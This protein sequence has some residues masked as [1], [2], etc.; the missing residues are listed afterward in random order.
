L[1][2][3]IL[4]GAC[5][6]TRHHKRKENPDPATNGSYNNGPQSPHSHFSQQEAPQHQLQANS[7]PVE[8]A[9]QNYQID[10]KEEMRQQV[11]ERDHPIYPRWREITPSPTTMSP[12]SS[13]YSPVTEANLSA[14]EQ[15]M[16][17]MTSYSGDQRSP[18]RN[19]QNQ[20]YYSA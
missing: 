14:L 20:T 6:I 7:I 3:A 17:P 15:Q 12:H 10:P 16:S 1:F 11:N 18:R 2:I 13:S 5:F 4:L 19:L 8:L 9:T